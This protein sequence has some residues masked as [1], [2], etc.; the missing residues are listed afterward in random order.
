[1]EDCVAGSENAFLRSLRSPTRDNQP[2]KNQKRFSCEHLLV[3]SPMDMLKVIN[4]DSVK[5]SNYPYTE[6]VFQL[7][8]LAY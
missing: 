5:L 7:F 4:N 8:N 2:V 6:L 3:P 1:M